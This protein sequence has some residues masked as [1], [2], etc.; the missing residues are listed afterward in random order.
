[1]LYQGR[2]LQKERSS[3]SF[4]HTASQQIHLANPQVL[5]EPFPQPADMISQI[6]IFAIFIF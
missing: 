1:M 4:D 2:Q 6:K 3:F 5:N